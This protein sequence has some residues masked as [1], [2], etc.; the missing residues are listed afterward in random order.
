LLR[1][2]LVY[3]AKSFYNRKLTQKLGIDIVDVPYLDAYLRKRFG[4]EY[5]LQCYKILP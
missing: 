4:E 5:F 1:L 2:N 3:V